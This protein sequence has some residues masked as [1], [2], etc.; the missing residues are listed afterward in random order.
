MIHHKTTKGCK[1]FWIFFLCCLFF[2]IC[3]C[4][5]FFSF[6]STSLPFSLCSFFRI[7]ARHKNTLL[8][9][10]LSFIYNEQSKPNIDDVDYLSLQKMPQSNLVVEIN[11]SLSLYKLCC[12]QI[13]SKSCFG[14]PAWGLESDEL[15]ASFSTWKALLASF[16]SMPITKYGRT[17]TCHVLIT[18]SVPWAWWIPSEDWAMAAWKRGCNSR[19]ATQPFWSVGR[20]W[21]VVAS[22]K[23][24]EDSGW[25]TQVLSTWDQSCGRKDVRTCRTSETRSVQ[26]KHRKGCA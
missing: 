12:V 13:E 4:S 11:S 7:A 19:W 22:S 9:R 10:T 3:W 15:W 25:K 21:L 1:Y 23:A 17:H 14:S 6:F 18:L 8:H 5:F 20:S 16:I 26:T 2:F 24:T